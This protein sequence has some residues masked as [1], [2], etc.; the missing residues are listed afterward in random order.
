MGFE[1][2]L[3]RIDKKNWNQI[4]SHWLRHLPIIDPIGTPPVESLSGH[5]LLAS[6]VL[7]LTKDGEKKEDLKNL[8]SILFHEAIFLLHKSINVLEASGS[9]FSEGFST[10]SLSG[11]YQS[12]YFAAKSVLSF[13]GVTFPRVNGTDIILDGWPYPEELKS[14][15]KKLGVEP[16]ILV[17]LIREHPIQHFHIWGTLKRIINTCDISTTLWPEAY[18]EFVSKI[19]DFASQRNALHYSNYEWILNDIHDRLIIPY[20]GTRPDFKSDL[21]R[22]NES[23]DDFSVLLSYVLISLS[24]V[25]LEDIAKVAPA[26]KDEYELVKRKLLRVNTFAFVTD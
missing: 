8:R 17:K 6:A 23:T 15:Q 3:K 18:T 7:G 4:R 11:G 24:Y 19:D 20:F 12:A 9:N 21:A 22:V 5:P 1:L 16:E 13:M 10:W 14:K 26:I 25:L 2:K